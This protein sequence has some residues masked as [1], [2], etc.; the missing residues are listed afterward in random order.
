MDYAE[1]QI[2]AGYDAVGFPH[3]ESDRRAASTITGGLFSAVAGA[4]IVSVPAAGLGC[5]V[6]AVVGGIAGGILGTAAAG[7][8]ALF[9]M[10]LGAGAGCL[11]G[12]VVGAVPGIIVGAGTG[13]VL[14]AAAGA[15]LGGGVDVVKPDVPPLIDAATEPG[16]MNS[17][18]VVEDPPITVDPVTVVVQQAVA[19]VTPAIEGTIT[20][21][22]T[23][24]GAFPPM[25]PEFF[26]PFVAPV[27][28]LVAAATAGL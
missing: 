3:E 11:A 27:R 24:V 16:P 18:P 1:W 26:G 2:A 25:D 9:G 13:A 14:G 15:A 21:L 20:S 4:E 10:G 28:D 8:G 6:G 7:I 17:V 19:T 23:A 5:G 22:S 12:I